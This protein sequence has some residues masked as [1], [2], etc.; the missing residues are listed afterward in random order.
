MK[1]KLGI[2]VGHYGPGTGTSH[3]AIDEWT[4][5]FVDAGY[6]M[7]MICA[8]LP[9]VDPIVIVIDRRTAMWTSVGSELNE[10]G[11]LKDRNQE[12]RARWA[13]ASGCEAFIE[14]HY[15]ADPTGKAHGH[16]T[17]YDD[18]EMDGSGAVKFAG[19][20]AAALT[21]EFTEHPNRGAKP[22][23]Y[24][25]LDI[26]RRS[27]VPAVIVEPAF[28]TEPLIAAPDWHERYARALVD[29]IGKYFE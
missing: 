25:V 17:F 2:L 13:I 8:K 15:N 1:R 20:I 4:M 11:G 29:G 14:L 16:E 22:G 12:L 19:L 24:Q 3:E 23:R 10:R 26:A 5:A 18:N 28:I 6:L 9:D 7:R 27:M 21:A